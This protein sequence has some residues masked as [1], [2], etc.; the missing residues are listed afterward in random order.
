MPNLMLDFAMMA[1]DSYNGDA[2]GYNDWAKTKCPWQRDIGVAGQKQV[3]RFYACV[4]KLPRAGIAVVA[5]RGTDDLGDTLVDDVGG[6]GLSLNALALRLDDAVD[7]ASLYR[8]MFKDLWVVGHSLGGAYAQLVSAA[9]GV[10]G[11]SFNAPGVL[12]LYNQLSPSR[13]RRFIGAATGSID[14]LLGLALPFYE[15]GLTKAV[16]GAQDLPA[17]ANLRGHMDPVSLVGAHLGA[18]L[19][20]IRV[21]HNSPHPHSMVPIIDALKTRA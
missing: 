13:V 4:Y 21:P 2:V 11:V 19:Q 1:H 15:S 20:T 17:V 6:I 12:H 3:G 5:Y 10:P 18:P 8:P 14:A 9:L 16:S 7:F